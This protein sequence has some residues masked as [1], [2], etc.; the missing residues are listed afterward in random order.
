MCVPANVIYSILAVDELLEMLTHEVL[1][2]NC[3]VCMHSYNFVELFNKC[4]HKSKACQNVMP[5]FESIE[6]L[7]RHVSPLRTWI[8][9]FASLQLKNSFGSICAGISLEV[10]FELFILSGCS[11]ATRADF[12]CLAPRPTLLSMHFKD[13]ASSNKFLV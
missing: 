6:K 8:V 13:N 12:E 10:N 4:L 2:C 3:F 9:A 11:F 5:S 7:S 1:P